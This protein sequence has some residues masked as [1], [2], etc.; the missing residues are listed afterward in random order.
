[1]AENDKKDE[2]AGRDN[3]ARRRL[4]YL[5]MRSKELRAEMLANKKETDEIRKKMGVGPKTKRKKDGEE[6]GAEGGED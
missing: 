3:N 5:K 4:S 2:K 1:M 6:G